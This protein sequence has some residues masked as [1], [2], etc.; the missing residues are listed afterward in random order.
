VTLHTAAAD[1]GQAHEVVLVLESLVKKISTGNI[2]P[3]DLQAKGSSR[4]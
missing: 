1:I 2:R 4:D 3:I